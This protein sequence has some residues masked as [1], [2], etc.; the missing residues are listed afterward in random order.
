MR[1]SGVSPDGGLAEII[2]LADHPW[3]LAVQFHPE[4]KSKPNRAHPIFSG[5]IEAALSQCADERTSDVVQIKS[6]RTLK[7]ILAERHPEI[8]KKIFDAGHDVV[9][10]GTSALLGIALITISVLDLYAYKT[11]EATLDDQLQTFAED[12]SR[13]AND[14]IKAAVGQLARLETAVDRPDFPG[15]RFP[16]KHGIDDLALQGVHV[17]PP[18]RR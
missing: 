4:F 3:F 6:S 2:E 9:L 15:P 18:A 8:V 12:I 13:H 7:L 11:L 1:L 10:V 17:A 16:Q 5:F 14:E